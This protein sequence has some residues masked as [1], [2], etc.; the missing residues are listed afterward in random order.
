MHNDECIMHNCMSN[1]MIIICLMFLL[2]NIPS[3]GGAWG[4]L[5]TP[6]SLFLYS[7]LSLYIQLRAGQQA[8]LFRLLNR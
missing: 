8:V 4:G 7:L 5:L 2:C 1:Y 3:F 6:F